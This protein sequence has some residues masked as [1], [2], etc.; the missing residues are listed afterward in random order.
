[1]DMAALISRDLFAGKVICRESDARKFEYLSDPEGFDRVLEVI[2][3]I[4]LRIVVTSAQSGYFAAEEDT[5]D[6]AR[7][8]RASV[9]TLARESQ[10]IEE[11]QSFLLDVFPEGELL[12]SGSQ[13]NASEL[14]EAVNASQVLIDELDHLTINLNMRSTTTARR[15]SNLLS[16]LAK[17]G[18]LVCRNARTEQYVATA[19]VDRAWDVTEYLVSKRPGAVESVEAATQGDLFS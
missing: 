11:L 19:K 9:E 7:H 6:A 17:D 13:I 2:A 1:M 16:N 10:R 12:R 18:Y 8:L 15:V 14:L 3:P 5:E 4:G